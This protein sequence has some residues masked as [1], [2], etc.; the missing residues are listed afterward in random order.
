MKKLSSIIVPFF[1]TIFFY[2]IS[3]WLKDN[4]SFFDFE[5]SE[6][7]L[8]QLFNFVLTLTVL[9][10]TLFIVRSINIILFEYLLINKFKIILPKFL[11]QLF[12]IM[13][14]VVVIILVLNKIYGISLTVLVATS[15]AIGVGIA[16]GMRDIISDI[17]AGIALSIE[18]PFSINDSIELEDGVRGVVSEMTWRSTFISTIYETTMV[19]PNSKI[20]SMKVINLNRPNEFYQIRCEFYF[21]YSTSI[22]KVKNIIESVLEVENISQPRKSQ[23]V[24]V[25]A[26]DTEGIKYQ[27]VIYV[28]SA[29]FE[30]DIKSKILTKIVQ[31]LEKSNIQPTYKNFEITYKKHE[32]K[33]FNKVDFLSKI[34]LFKTLDKRQLLE[35]SSLIKERN[36]KAD[37]KII[38][39]G[40]I[41]KS[42]FILVDGLVEVFKKNEQEKEISISYIEVGSYFGEFS[43]LTGNPRSATV[44]SKSD[45]LL[46]EISVENMRMLLENDST[47]ESYLSE[48][49][50]K[51]EIY[52]KSIIN[53]FYDNNENEEK[54]RNKIVEKMKKIFKKS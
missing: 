49:L 13:I 44:I 50:T 32:E 38:T 36:Y 45:T 48:I 6:K 41:D 28:R 21:N 35:F 40:N 33:E 9:F 15:S 7:I 43:L 31:N 18:K 5:Y 34:D 2:L 29:L 22:D 46:Y 16:Y 1:L 47:L 4:L 27:I 42:L 11:I 24:Y 10:F 54:I 8:F 3:I 52:N 51:R 23:K 53:K 30:R 19:V 14:F 25:V 26:L 12:D 17:F 20:N 37:E 39:E